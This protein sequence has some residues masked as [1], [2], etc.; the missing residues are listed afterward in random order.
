[1]EF[2]KIQENEISLELNP[3][4]YNLET[5]YSASYQMLE[6]AFI[7]FEGDPDET[8][9]VLI[10]NQESTKNTPEELTKLA[11]KF[12][13]LL[14]NYAYYK[15]NSKNKE[16]LRTLLLK[17]SFESINS[18][19]CETQ[20]NNP[21]QNAI[22]QIDN[23]S[24]EEEYIPTKNTFDKDEDDVDSPI[25]E[26]LEFDDPDEIAIPWEDKFN[27]E[28]ELEFDDPDEI[29]I[30]WEDDEDDENTNKE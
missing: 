15:I 19:Q 26:D 13:N 16:S 12:L 8:I 21:S 4:L 5:I 10:S 25:N 28:E 24:D 22:T 7:R 23:F 14:I 6:E 17:K 18:E 2:F 9:K 29:T 20:E 11:K 27:S 1:M 3:K 30:P